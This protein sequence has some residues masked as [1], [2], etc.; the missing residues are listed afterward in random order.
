M[1]SVRRL[2][3]AA[4]SM[5]LLLCTRAEAEPRFG[6]E[7]WGS[8]N[9][10]SMSGANDTLSSFNQEYGTALPPIRD[11]ASWGFGLR[12]WPRK[13]VLMRLGFDRLPAQSQDSGVEF[14]LGAYAI[15]LGATR[16]LPS[17]GRTRFGLGLGL[18]PYFA[19]G[20]LSAPGA[21]LSASGTGFGVHVAGEAAVAIGAGCSLQSMIG[22]RWASI[23]SLKYGEYPSGVSANYS[24]PFV[25]V[26]LAFD[27]RGD[28]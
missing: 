21:T 8:W 5:A 14:D 9:Q 19:T 23:G 24:G 28:Q 2:A 26:G 15:T 7:G 1:N 25:R 6:I 27:G 10:F 17:S 18:G 22:Y 16:Y 12:L 4:V 20:G 11:N 13:D 3:L